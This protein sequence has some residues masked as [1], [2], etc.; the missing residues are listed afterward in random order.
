MI[1]RY[2]RDTPFPNTFRCW[3]S[4]GSDFLRHRDSK[5]YEPLAY[6]SLRKRARGKRTRVARKRGLVRAGQAN[7]KNSPV[8]GWRRSSPAAGVDALSP[9]SAWGACAACAVCAACV[10]SAACDTADCC[11]RRC[12]SSRGPDSSRNR[13]PSPPASPSP[14]HTETRTGRRPLDFRRSFS[15]SRHH[16]RS[17]LEL[18]GRRGAEKFFSRRRAARYCGDELFIAAR[19]NNCP[20]HGR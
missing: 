16:R 9:I 18:P 8:R 14:L 7:M 15:S 2:G 10:V 5:N 1:L 19:D 13:R 11:H 12:S 4:R 3:S 17:L 20:V 6:G